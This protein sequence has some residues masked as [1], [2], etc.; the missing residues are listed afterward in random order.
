MQMQLQ[1]QLKPGV[2]IVYAG[3]FSLGP[4][5]TCLL[6]APAAGS[7][8]QVNAHVSTLRHGSCVMSAVA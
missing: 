1:L 8:A 7:A 4:C 5:V 2:L 6:V 3:V